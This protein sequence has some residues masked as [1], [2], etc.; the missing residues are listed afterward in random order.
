[1]ILIRLKEIVKYK[2]QESRKAVTNVEPDAL[3]GSSD[4]VRPAKCA[5]P[6][7][8]IPCIV[9]DQL[10]NIFFQEWSP[11][12]PVLHCQTFLDIHKTYESSPE[13]IKDPVSVAQLNLVFGTA[14]LANEV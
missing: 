8:N 11:L 3:F 14:A 9:S 7:K 4:L 10:I 5:D 2:I 1:M 13:L 6:M 12:F